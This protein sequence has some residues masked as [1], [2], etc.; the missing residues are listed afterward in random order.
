MDL[1]EGNLP[2]REDMLRIGE[3]AHRAAKMS[4]RLMALGRQDSEPPPDHGS[5]RRAAGP[6][7]PCSRCCC[8]GSRGWR[9]SSSPPDP[10]SGATRQPRAIRRLLILAR[11]GGR[12][13]P[14]R[15]MSSRF[16]RLPS[17]RSMTTSS[18]R[19]WMQRRLL[20]SWASPASGGIESMIYNGIKNYYNFCYIN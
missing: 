12:L 16:G 18:A 10:W 15:S 20:M 5:R 1:D 3:A 19:L 11:R 6:S 14:M 13:P 8:P 7:S 4:S 17:S 2:K 9:A